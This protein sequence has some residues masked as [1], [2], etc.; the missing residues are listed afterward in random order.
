VNVVALDKLT[1]R[2]VFVHIC[3]SWIVLCGGV[4][5][6]ILFKTYLSG[7][8]LI[9]AAFFTLASLLVRA[10]V[11]QHMKAQSSTTTRTSE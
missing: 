5:N 4:L 7:F 1:P 3:G 10:K 2:T 6:V 9:A 11:E 8:A